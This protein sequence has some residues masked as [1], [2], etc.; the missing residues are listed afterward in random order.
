M[1]IRLLK[2]RERMMIR[3]SDVELLF[4]IW[5]SCRDTAVPG[6]NTYMTLGYIDHFCGRV[7]FL[8]A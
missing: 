7:L 5:S 1:N 3:T 6:D 2:Q 4:G 8:I